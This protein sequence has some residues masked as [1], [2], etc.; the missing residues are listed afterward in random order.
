MIEIREP[1]IE[2]LIMQRLQRGAFQ[3]IEE[4]LYQALTEAPLPRKALPV[5]TTADM[6]AAFQRSP[7]KEVD[8]EPER[9]AMAISD[10]IEF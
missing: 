4:V 8:L 1:E 9:T 3:N 5:L 2:A 7:Y 10:P 6:L